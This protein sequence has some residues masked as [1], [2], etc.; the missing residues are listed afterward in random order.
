MS[1]LVFGNHPRLIFSS[2]SEM[3]ESIGYLA[4]KSGLSIRREDNHNQGAWGPEYRIYV[5]EP[6]DNASGALRNKASKGVGN[7]VARIN[8]NEF[9]LL[10]F[11]KYGFVMGDSQNI[12]SI[13]A[14]IP[15]GYLS[16]FERG[17][18]FAA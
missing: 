15:S 8:C 17:V 13:R 9:I 10:L 14:S 18:A 7:V 1:Q 12:T 4:R 16:D 2:E 6:L 3:Y 11:E 5:Y